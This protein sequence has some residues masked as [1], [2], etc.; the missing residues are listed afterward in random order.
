MVATRHMRL[1]LLWER[2]SALFGTYVLGST[3]SLEMVFCQPRPHNLCILL[4]SKHLTPN[5][6][7]F[8]IL[9]VL[10]HQHAD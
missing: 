9:V 7:L 6:W 3:V 10:D 2:V 5:T 8:W 1:L 4:T